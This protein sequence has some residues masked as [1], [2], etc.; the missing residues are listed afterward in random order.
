M[1]PIA[2][3]QSGDIA[4]RDT[5]VIRLLWRS[6]LRQSHTCGISCTDFDAVEIVNAKISLS[7]G[8]CKIDLLTSAT[9]SEGEILAEPNLDCIELEFVVVVY[10]PLQW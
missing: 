1:V 4:G 7:A 6:K 3:L 2:G 10:R 5:D 9:D 8:D